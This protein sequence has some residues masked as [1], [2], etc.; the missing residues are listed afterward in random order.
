MLEDIS[1]I[2]KL[3]VD[4]LSLYGVGDMGIY[5]LDSGSKWEQISSSIPDKVLSVAVGSDKLYIATKQRGIFHILLEEKP[6]K[7]D[8]SLASVKVD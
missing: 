5:R 4:G 6:L 8:E 7:I 1:V 2:D 3:T